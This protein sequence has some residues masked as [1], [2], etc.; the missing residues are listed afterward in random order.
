MRALVPHLLLDFFDVIEIIGKGR[1]NFGQGDRRHVGNDLV[2]GHALMLMPRNDI[3]HTDAVAGDAGFS[4]ADI[5]RPGDPVLRRRGHDS[6]IRRQRLARRESEQAG[7]VAF[8]LPD[9]LLEG[10]DAML[11]IIQLL[12]R[13]RLP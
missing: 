5:G 3:E 6:S 12:T 13:E 11:G 2:G 7:L 10:L 9:G 4:T 1:V 8:A